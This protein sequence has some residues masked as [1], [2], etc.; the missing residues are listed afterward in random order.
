MGT[1][2]IGQ[3]CCALKEKRE[4]NGGRGASRLYV[5]CLTENKDSEPPFE[6]VRVNKVF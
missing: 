1:E 3:E 4:R 5:L 2:G 6:K